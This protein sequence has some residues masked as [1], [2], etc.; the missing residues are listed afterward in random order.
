MFTKKH[1]MH[2]IFTSN[3]ARIFNYPCK[4]HRE[5]CIHDPDLTE[6]KGIPPHLWKL[7][8][9]KILPMTEGEA[10]IRQQ[11]VDTHGADNNVEKVAI[12]SIYRPYFVFIRNN[13]KLGVSF[14]L[15]AATSYLKIKGVL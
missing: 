10:N 7:E 4:D 15:G 6:V 12:K 14:L 8:K 3:N 11:H 2:V 1:K 9:G 13:W 5:T